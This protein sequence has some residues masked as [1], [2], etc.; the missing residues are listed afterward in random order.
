MSVISISIQVHCVPLGVKQ[1]CLFISIT[2]IK[3][4]N[5]S[6]QLFAILLFIILC[7]LSFSIV[8]SVDPEAEKLCKARTVM[9]WRAKQFSAAI[10]SNF[11]S[12]VL[13]QLV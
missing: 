9:S 5:I 2:E 12:K 10:G 6:T 4:F 11:N 8:C 1:Y 7:L 13:F 3:P